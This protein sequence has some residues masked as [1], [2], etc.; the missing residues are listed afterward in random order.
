MKKIEKLSEEYIETILTDQRNMNYEIAY[1]DGIRKG[2]ELAREEVIIY[3]DSDCG[4]DDLMNELEEEV[5]D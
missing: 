1:Q 2:I 4:I 5:S 3:E